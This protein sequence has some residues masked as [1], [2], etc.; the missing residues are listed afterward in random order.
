[1]ERQGGCADV[2]VE[3][4]KGNLVMKDDLNSISR[5]LERFKTESFIRKD[6]P[7]DK[8]F[9]VYTH[10]TGRNMGCYKTKKE[11]ENRLKEIHQFS[12]K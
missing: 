11:A 12:S 7:T 3:T 4:K 9:C 5:E 8:P 2:I 1:M 6:G 10:Q